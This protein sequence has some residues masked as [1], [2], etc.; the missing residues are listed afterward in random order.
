[1]HIENRLQLIEVLTEGVTQGDIRLLKEA[2]MSCEVLDDTEEQ[3]AIFELIR[4]TLHLV[5]Q[6]LKDS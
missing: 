3:E 4:A 5:E 2:E 6:T 1:M